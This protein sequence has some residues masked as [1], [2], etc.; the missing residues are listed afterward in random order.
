MADYDQ[1]T[2]G[3]LA[4]L[5]TLGEAEKL[6]VMQGI[7]EGKAK[8]LKAKDEIDI[9]F[10]RAADKN[11][12]P[13]IRR[14]HY[15]AA[16]AAG[17]ALGMSQFA[18]LPAIDSMDPIAE[19]TLNAMGRDIELEGKGELPKGTHL[20]NLSFHVA[21]AMAANKNRIST[22]DLM[23]M[24]AKLQT[25]Q[26]MGEGKL[27]TYKSGDKEITGRVD[28]TGNFN[29]ATANG[30]PIEAPNVALMNAQNQQRGQDQDQ[31]RLDLQREAFYAR[32]GEQ[33]RKLLND[34]QKGD[35]NASAAA[36]ALMASFPSL[37]S[38]LGISAEGE[39]I[40][41]QR[42]AALEDVQASKA[43][44]KGK[45][46]ELKD[47]SKSGGAKTPKDKE[48]DLTWNGKTIKD[49]PANR[50]WL[51]AQRA[52]QGKGNGPANTAATRG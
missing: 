34:L 20:K 35:K 3:L 40:Q 11:Y 19:A 43:A 14:Q 52:K 39:D 13:E 48:F 16:I 22:D 5:N 21:Q 9:H 32:M 41:A 46:T 33:E 7:E 45:S 25:M 4:G 23:N 30:K 31:E 15:N 24:P 50:K 44:V 2:K 26:E 28:A 27:D 29:A 10:G 12:D 49:T 18:N 47:T 1:A 17:R 38:F 37:A 8:Y 42:Q 36:K 6:K 51:T